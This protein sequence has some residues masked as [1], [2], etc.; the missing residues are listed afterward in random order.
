MIT[1]EELNDMTRRVGRERRSCDDP[2]TV[3]GLSIAECDRL[4]LEVRTL[5]DFTER[6]VEML[7]GECDCDGRGT[8][9]VLSDAQCIHCH[10]ADVSL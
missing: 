7:G 1:Y 2:T 5:R 8:T 4:L 3:K 10:G 6:A 9:R